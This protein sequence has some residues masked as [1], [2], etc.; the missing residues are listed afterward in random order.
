MTYEDR[1]GRHTHAIREPQT[2]I[3]RGGAGYWVDLKVEA[4]QDV[5]REHVRLRRD[6]GSGQFLL[7]DL[8]TY[9]TTVDG[10]AVPSSIDTTAGS[11]RD[12]NLE[13]PLPAQARIGLADMV[14]L[15]FRLELPLSSPPAMPR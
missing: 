13:V 12:V 3:G 15:E 1:S 11:K 5:S 7:K 10:V 6:E 8:S 4:A 14:F 9:G 2:V